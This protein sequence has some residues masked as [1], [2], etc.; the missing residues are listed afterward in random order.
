MKP[1]AMPGNLH[2]VRL[3]VVLLLL[4]LREKVGMRGRAAKRRCLLITLSPTLSLQGRGRGVAEITID[5]VG[6]PVRP[7]LISDARRTS[8]AATSACQR[9]S[10]CRDSR[11]GSALM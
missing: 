4:P 8:A 1:S 2:E 5:H 11:S 7:L 9:G 3:I 10:S 6:L